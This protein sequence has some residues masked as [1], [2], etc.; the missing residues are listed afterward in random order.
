MFIDPSI[1]LEV[2]EI[3]FN[4][5]RIKPKRDWGSGIEFEWDI[6]EIGNHI[7]LFVEQNP[8]T[9]EYS[10]RTVSY[11]D[12]NRVVKYSIPPENGEIRMVYEVE[13]PDGTRSK[14]V[15]VSEARFYSPIKPEA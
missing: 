12:S 2:I 11:F 8:F 6:V 14:S 1:A 5:T 13:F 3:W 9:H 15:T 10:F 7:K 4:G